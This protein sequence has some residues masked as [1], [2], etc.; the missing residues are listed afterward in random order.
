[1]SAP[2]V[3]RGWRNRHAATCGRCGQRVEPG[4][5]SLMGKPGDWQVSHL[6]CVPVVDLTKYQHSGDK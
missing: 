4:D 6:S 2:V 1:M 3:S 5:G